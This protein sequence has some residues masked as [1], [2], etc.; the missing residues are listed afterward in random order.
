MGTWDTQIISDDYV[1]DVV[2]EFFELYNDGN[3]PS[4]IRT[5]L[6][7]KE[8]ESIKDSEE[9]Y[10]FWFALANAQ[11]DIGALDSDVLE[12]VRHI[13]QENIDTK[14]WIAKGAS[15]G[16]IQKRKLVT[17][18]FLKKLE[19]LN[20]KP[21]KRKKITLQDSPF[22][23]GDILIFKFADGSYGATA[24]FEAQKQSKLGLTGLAK[25]DIRQVEKPTL[26]EVREANLLATGPSVLNGGSEKVD[27]GYHSF[28]YENVKTKFER[29]GNIPIKN[30]P[31]HNPSFARWET[32]F[33]FVEKQINSPRRKGAFALKD[34]IL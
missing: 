17:T 24:V 33:P 29:I 6:E 7:K 5:K 23:K 34:F 13:V 32:F 26:G 20:P 10:L 30:L 25:T 16:D 3:E 9:G 22:E 27:V 28:G 14:N 2:A 21:K 18:E 15:E 11:W 31:I 1:A 4:E 19:V 12:T 8:A